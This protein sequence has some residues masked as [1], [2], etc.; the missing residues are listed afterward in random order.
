M[1]YVA[2]EIEISRPTVSD[3]HVCLFNLNKR[4]VHYITTHTRVLRIEISSRYLILE[5][6]NRN[7]FVSVV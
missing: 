4:A 3:V 5:S 1:V 7:V 2:I 6:G